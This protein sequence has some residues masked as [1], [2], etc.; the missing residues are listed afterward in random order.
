MHVGMA[1]IFQNPNN[2]K[3]VSDYAIYQQDMALAYA[4]F[5]AALL[6]VAARPIAGL[7]LDLDEAAN[8]AAVGLAVTFLV[9]AGLFQ[10]FDSAQAAASGMLRGLGDTRV[11]MIYAALGYWGIGMPVAVVLGF[12]TPLAGSGIWIGLSVALV[13]AA[14]LLTTRWARRDRLGLTRPYEEKGGTPPPVPAA[15]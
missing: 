9:F 14:A 11:P 3:G 2:D 4:A 13:A 10:L 8:Q 12:A 1:S 15:H 6:I 7:F 5:A